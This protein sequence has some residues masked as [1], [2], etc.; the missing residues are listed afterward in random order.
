MM[1][2][3]ERFYKTLS[4]WVKDDIQIELQ[5]KEVKNKYSSS[6]R[7]YH[8]LNHLSEMFTYY[9]MY[10]DKLEYPIELSYAIFY[11]DIIYNSISKQNELNSAELAIDYLKDTEIESKIKER[12]FNLI[13]VTKDHKFK[14]SN[15]EKWM[16]DFDLGILGQSWERYYLYTKEIRK[17]YAFAP[18]FMYKNGRK[19]VLKHFLN[20]SKIYKTDVFYELF[21]VK[22]RKNIKKE[23]EI[24]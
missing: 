6:S 19:K 11:H 4:Y 3:Q 1:N 18:N 12:V 10:K 21:E 9:D 24:L 23:L 13:M 2:L 14:E 20:K 15:D 8:N 5:W 7:H 17:E 16:I 22:A